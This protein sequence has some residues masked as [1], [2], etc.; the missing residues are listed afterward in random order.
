[1]RLACENCENWGVMYMCDL[2][3]NNF[4]QDCMGHRGWLDLCTDCEEGEDYEEGYEEDD[5]ED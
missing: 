4:C 1:M 3:G 2:C 5:E